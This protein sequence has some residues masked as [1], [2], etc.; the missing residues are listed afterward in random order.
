VVT[1]VQ[2]PTDALFSNTALHGGAIVLEFEGTQ[3][4]VDDVG[5][6]FTVGLVI[7]GRQF[8]DGTIKRAVRILPYSDPDDI[9]DRPADEVLRWTTQRLQQGVY[10]TLDDTPLDSD[11]AR[12]LARALIDAADEMDGLAE[13]ADD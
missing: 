1:S 13:W 10:A 2:P 9:P 4:H 7:E 6:G 5:T 12:R 8:P 3:R 11:S